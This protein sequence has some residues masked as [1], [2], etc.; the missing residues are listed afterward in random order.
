MK[1][2]RLLQVVF[3]SSN[4]LLAVPVLAASA[5]AQGVDQPVSLCDGEKSEKADKSDKKS[6]AKKETKG[7]K[8]APK[9]PATT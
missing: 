9:E 4:V 6:D 1:I 3:V 5:P 7:D 2:S 8:P